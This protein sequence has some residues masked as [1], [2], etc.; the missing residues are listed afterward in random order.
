MAE[1]LNGS[2]EASRRSPRPRHRRRFLLAYALL[3]LLAAAA[4]AAFALLLAARED[5]GSRPAPAGARWSDW[6][7]AARGLEG[8]QQIA[9]HVARRYRLPSGRPLVV[10]KAG[11]LAIEDVRISAVAVQTAAGGEEATLQLTPVERGVAYA[12]C[13]LGARCSISEGKPS[14]ERGRRVRREALE[15]ALYTF[16]Y[17]DGVDSVVAFLPPV[18]G[19]RGSF[20]LYFRPSDLEAALA[21]PLQE[22]LSEAIP[23]LPRPLDPPE[24][25]TVDGLTV[26]RVFGFGLQQ[27]QDG[28]AMLVLARPAA[29]G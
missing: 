23:P 16:K 21:R 2:S 6:R 25:R 26:P 3:V 29:R 20:I 9:D 19:S 22:T 24:A 7:P 12:M 11:P 8:A 15:L 17:L 14:S 27:L 10:V 1:A 4:A 5:G 28:T 13:G 18:P